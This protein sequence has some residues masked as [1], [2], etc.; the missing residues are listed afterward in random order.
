MVE[1]VWFCYS[2]LNPFVRRESTSYEVLDLFGEVVETENES[3]RYA[4]EIYCNRCHFPLIAHAYLTTLETEKL[5]EV[6]RLIHELYEKYDGQAEGHWEI[7]FLI[8]LLHAHEKI[9]LEIY[10]VSSGK[11][12]TLIVSPIETISRLERFAKEFNAIEIVERYEKIFGQSII[13]NQLKA[14]ARS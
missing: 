9:P 3:E 5:A 4:T 12:E 8:L 1:E 10:L 13:T 11:H 7:P 14:I 2:C 6:S